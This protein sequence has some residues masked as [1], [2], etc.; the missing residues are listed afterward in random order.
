M[1]TRSFPAVADS[2][3]ASRQFAAD[4]LRDAAPELVAAALLMVSEL[5]TNAVKHAGTDFVVRVDHR[6]GGLRFAVTDGG[7]EEPQMKSPEPHEPSGR[8]LRIVNQL[9]DDWGIDHE[10]G[11]KT[12]WFELRTSVEDADSSVSGNMRRERPFDRVSTTGPKWASHRRIAP[13]VARPHDPHGHDAS[14]PT[15][16]AHPLGRILVPSC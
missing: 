15:S 12:V 13:T 2:V 5:A 16:G 8:G 14:T 4:E 11:R 10:S 9:A 6:P 1:T 7:H 3:P